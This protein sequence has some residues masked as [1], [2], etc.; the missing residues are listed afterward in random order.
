MDLA[1]SFR[2]NSVTFSA[3][4]ALRQALHGI[5]YPPN[6]AT[7]R[8]RLFG[9]RAT[10]WRGA[11]WDHNYHDSLVK[12]SQTHRGHQDRSSVRIRNE[13]RSSYP[14]TSPHPHIRTTG[15]RAAFGLVPID[16]REWNTPSPRHRA[17]Y[18]VA[19]FS[20]APRY[21]SKYAQPGSSSPC[22]PRFHPRARYCPRRRVSG[23][24][25]PFGL[26]PTPKPLPKQYRC[27]HSRP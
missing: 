6:W 4:K 27:R 24:F 9:W 8:T 21:P 18:S 15:C 5:G 13:S 11:L 7:G 23:Y 25:Q 17:R 12:L 16:Q 20:R 26:I 2:S 3:Q 19:A 14:Q 1:V 22:R 10:R